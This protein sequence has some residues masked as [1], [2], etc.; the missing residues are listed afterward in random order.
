MS[1]Y[2]VHSTHEDP[3]PNAD[4]DAYKNLPHVNGVS[5]NKKTL[6]NFATLIEGMDK[7]LGDLMNH[8]EALGVADKTLIIF[9]SDNGGDAPIQQSYN[10]NVPWIEV[11][12]A[13]APLRGRKGNRYEGGT[14]IPMI[15]G[16]AKINA[17]CAVQR[18]Y[19]IPTGGVNHDIVAI[20]DMYPTI[21][22]FLKIPV[23]T[24]QEIDG[25]DIS[26]YFTGDGSFRRTQKIYQHFP[27][28]HTYANFYSSYREGDWK[29]IFNYMDQYANPALYSG[30]G[31]KTAG[32]FPWQMF[33]LK[34]DIGESHD[35]ANHPA[36]Q[37]RLMRMARALIRELNKA[38]AQ[39]P[40]LT[41][42]PN[43]KITGTAYIRMP[44]LPKI[45]SDG[46]G[47]PDLVEDANTNGIIDSGETDPDISDAVKGT[48]IYS[49]PGCRG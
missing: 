33:N 3:D 21:L 20:W 35:L 31:Y 44:D 39:Y 46:D 19:R 18:E 47:V 25:E 5:L 4:Y 38:N 45:D 43:G 6:R 23:P 9:L 13:V 17:N 28:R 10:G 41:T 29:V 36:H 32:R 11:I 8:L 14:R 2:A 22:G 24:E 16:W 34:D 26:P 15:M 12:G 49:K 42:A 27:H 30:N 1:H 7:S 37:A 40:L 48:S